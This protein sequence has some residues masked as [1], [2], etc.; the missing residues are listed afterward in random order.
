MQTLK[1][2]SSNNVAEYERMVAACREAIEAGG[3]DENSLCSKM[4]F[5][6]VDCITAK[7]DQG[8]IRKGTRC[9]DC[10]EDNPFR[11]YDEA[12]MCPGTYRFRCTGYK[13]ADY[14]CMSCGLTRK[15]ASIGP[16]GEEVPIR[17]PQLDIDVYTA[18]WISLIT[19]YA[20]TPPRPLVALP[21]QTQLFAKAQ[22]IFSL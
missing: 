21:A 12:G 11:E 17:F 3:K 18:S 8:F 6:D 14:Y 10:R 16:D 1:A 5:L 19:D 7:T 13:C 2:K 15:A 4:H 9:K 20:Q 22:M